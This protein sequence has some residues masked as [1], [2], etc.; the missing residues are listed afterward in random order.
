MNEFVFIS[1]LTKSRKHIIDSK[2]VTERLLLSL[3][4]SSVMS[5]IQ[6][7]VCSLR[8]LTDRG[9][10]IVEGWKKYQKLIV[11]EVGIVGRFGKNWKL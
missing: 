11:G 3:L 7:R 9:C 8:Y 6:E 4:D 1:E 2:D 5:Q 10:G